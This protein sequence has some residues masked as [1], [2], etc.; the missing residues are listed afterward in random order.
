MV[1]LQVLDLRS[2]ILFRDQRLCQA[3]RHND[4]A[5]NLTEGSLDPVMM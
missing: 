5:T 4:L 1:C 2:Q 3:S